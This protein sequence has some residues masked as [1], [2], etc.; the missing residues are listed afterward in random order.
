MDGKPVGL[1]ASTG[2]KLSSTDGFGSTITTSLIRRSTSVANAWD[3]NSN[4]HM[5][6]GAGQQIEPGQGL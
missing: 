2:L 3:S 5:K 1:Q 4:W 6:E